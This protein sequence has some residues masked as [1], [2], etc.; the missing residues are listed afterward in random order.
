M[1]H[2]TEEDL[3]EIDRDQ[4]ETIKHLENAEK[5]LDKILIYFETGITPEMQDLCKH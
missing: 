4:Q 5:C 3:E 1:E 2:L